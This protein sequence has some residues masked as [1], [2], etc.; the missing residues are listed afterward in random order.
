MYFR[1]NSGYTLLKGKDYKFQLQ[2][3]KKSKFL[4]IQKLEF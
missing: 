1:T 2:K 4:M 3:K